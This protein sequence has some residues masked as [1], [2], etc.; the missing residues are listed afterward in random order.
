MKKGKKRIKMHSI[1]PYKIK[2]C[3]AKEK[4]K[5][6]STSSTYYSNNF[7]Y[8]DVNQS[9]FLDY[10]FKGN[11]NKLYN[12]KNINFIKAKNYN[13]ELEQTF[14][15]NLDLLLSYYNKV[16]N[17]DKMK[18]ENKKE[19]ISLLINIRDKVKQKKET[20]EFIKQKCN[21]LI[22]K[23]DCA[24]SFHK[25]LDLQIN[26]YNTKLQNKLNEI[27]EST[28][29][30][31]KIKKRFLGVEKY[32]NKK[33]F[34]SEG[35]IHTQKK[36]KFKKFLHTNNKYI[37][38]IYKLILDIKKIKEN[39]SEIK[40]DNKLSRIQ[41]KLYKADKPN[42]NLIRVVEFY[43]RIIRKAALRKKN[44]QN[45]VNSLSKTL[46]F[47]D[48]NKIVNFNEFKRNRQRS[49]Y[50]I[51]F[52]NLEDNDCNDN[53]EINNKTKNIEMFMDFNKVLNK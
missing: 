4:S 7:C 35:K 43:I 38:K 52:S 3:S 13:Y 46:E 20:L 16:N 15:I 22:S 1:S 34:N 39:I 45:S 40:K 23:N 17:E 19:I 44:L 18:E 32:V 5:T 49:S 27:E 9:L 51:E 11:R 33:R 10:A 29:Y 36:S 47:L 30:I 24:N 2:F 42:I 8:T 25:R 28:N 21:Q 37:Y 41:N 48:L 12:N 26:Q 14:K 31:S 50:E 53:K 6:D